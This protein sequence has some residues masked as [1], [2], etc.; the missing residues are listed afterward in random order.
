YLERH[1]ANLPPAKLQTAAWTAI[2][3]RP[4]VSEVLKHYQ[5]AFKAKELLDSGKPQDA[6]ATA[7]DAATG[8]TATDAYPNWVVYRAASA[9]GRQREALDALRRAISSPEPVPVIYEDLIFVYERAG[10][11]TAALDWTNKAIA[12]FGDAPRWSP[13]KIRL[14]RKAGRTADAEALT[15]SCSVHTPDWKR[16]CQAANRTPAGRAT[17]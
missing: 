14:L 10:N 2:T 5:L 6:Y 4:D 15:L 9:L 13:T 16:E 8:R 3:G 11:V 1:Y 17:R 12:T 7:K